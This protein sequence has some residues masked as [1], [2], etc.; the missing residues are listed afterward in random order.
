MHVRTWNFIP[1]PSTIPSFA[2]S[3]FSSWLNGISCRKKI[4]KKGS[5]FI[6]AIHIAVY[7]LY[8]AIIT[9]MEVLILIIV[10]DLWL[11]CATWIRH[12]RCYLRVIPI[13]SLLF[14]A[15]SFFSFRWTRCDVCDIVVWQ[16]YHRHCC[17]MI[18][19]DCWC[20]WCRFHD[21]CWCC[22]KVRTNVSVWVRAL[23]DVMGTWGWLLYYL[24]SGC[25]TWGT[26]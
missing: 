15:K 12:W 21:C 5:L 25:R 8:R 7:L 11:S 20:W 4:R 23:V 19:L 16:C 10:M 24:P 3:I 6:K 2:I 18:C 17:Q 26:P 14:L 1:S 22:I 9:I 13:P